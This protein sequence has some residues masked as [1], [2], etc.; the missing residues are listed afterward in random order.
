MSTWIQSNVYNRTTTNNIVKR[1]SL[2]KKQFNRLVWRVLV[3]QTLSADRS[4]PLL[5]HPFVFVAA[6]VQYFISHFYNHFI[7]NCLKNHNIS[8]RGGPLLQ[9]KE[10]IV[11][12]CSA[13]MAMGNRIIPHTWVV[14]MVR[15]N[16]RSH[17]IHKPWL[18][19]VEKDN[20]VSLQKIRV[21]NWA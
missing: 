17:G 8:S 9:R 4:G 1:W 20:G 19:K 5:F 11:R 12:P 14:R 6:Y 18:Q 15:W 21:G 7:H 16:P 3:L 13:L 10:W 2:R